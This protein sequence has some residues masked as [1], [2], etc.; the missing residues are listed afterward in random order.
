MS[1]PEGHMEAPRGLSGQH[2]RIAELSRAG[3]AAAVALGRRL[4]LPVATP[5]VLANRG[6]LLLR[7]APAPVVARVATLSAWSRH[8]PSL[9]LAREISVAGYVAAAGG[10]VVP[11][12]RSVDPGPYLQDGFA[13]SLWEFAAGSRARPGAAEVGAALAGLHLAAAGC[14]AELG[15]LTPG[16][17]QISEGIDALERDVVL[18]P[19]AI[20]ALRAGHRRLLDQLP[21]RPALVLHGDAHA[22]NLMAAAGGWQWI[23]LEETCRGPAEWDLV[24]VADQAG[25][26]APAA[27]RAY[28]DAIGRPVPTAVELAPF[29]ELRMLEAVVWTNCMAHLHPARYQDQARDRL[30]KFL[31]G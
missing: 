3:Q 4:G 31:S 16:R 25:P 30:A 8:T 7:Y 14:P 18:G 28:A 21:D 19:E 22:G 11:P 12:C 26:A 9:W 27:L 10:P 15:E 29:H 1:E 24:C 20:A 23:D 17:E 5:A 6:N 13:I 2:S